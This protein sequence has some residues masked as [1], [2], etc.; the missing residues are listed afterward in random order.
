[1]GSYRPLL[2][3]VLTSEA[4]FPVMVKMKVSQFNNLPLNDHEWCV[5]CAFNVLLKHGVELSHCHVRL[6]SEQR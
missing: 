1:M 6:E 5:Y 3:S 2:T 4:I